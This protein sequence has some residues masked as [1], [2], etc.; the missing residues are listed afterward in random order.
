MIARITYIDADLGPLTATLGDDG[1]WTCD[2]PAMQSLLNTLLATEDRSPARGD[3]LAWHAEQ[4]A[5]MLDGTI[6]VE[7]KTPPTDPDLRY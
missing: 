5:E 7:P 4:M 2:D 6:E 3:W 1:A